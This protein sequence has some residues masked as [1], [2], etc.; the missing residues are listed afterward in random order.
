MNIYGIDWWSIN[1][2]R[3]TSFFRD[4]DIILAKEANLGY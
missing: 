2:M 1:Y 4:S 3:A